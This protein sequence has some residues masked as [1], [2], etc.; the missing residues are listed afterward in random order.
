[1]YAWQ[2]TDDITNYTIADLFSSVGK[3]TDVIVRFSQV[4]GLLGSPEWMRAPPQAPPL[5]SE[6]R[7]AHIPLPHV[8]AHANARTQSVKHRA[9]AR[10]S[11]SHI[12]L[13][14]GV[15]LAHIAM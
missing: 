8:S 9:A 5:L 2:V 14:V 3:S 4:T 7:L 11:T 10:K 13:Y 1:M 15:L 6:A 12:S